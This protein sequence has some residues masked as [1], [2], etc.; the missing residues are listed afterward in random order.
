VH[1]IIGA[2]AAAQGPPSN[3]DNMN[4]SLYDALKSVIQWTSRVVEGLGKVQWQQLGYETKADGT[5]DYS[6]PLY[7]IEVRERTSFL[8]AR[9]RSE[10]GS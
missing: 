1:D 9:D 6:H 3:S 2:A 10:N 5:P 8:H 7:K 4:V